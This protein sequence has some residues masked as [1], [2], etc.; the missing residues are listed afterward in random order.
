M[1]FS[2]H[3]HIQKPLLLVG[4]GGVEIPGTLCGSPGYKLIKARI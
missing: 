2:Q 4:G 1:P 3:V